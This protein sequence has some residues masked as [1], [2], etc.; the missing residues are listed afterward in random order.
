MAY[1]WQRTEF[2]GL[3]QAMNKTVE[4]PCVRNC[5]LDKQ[6]ICIGCGRTV[7]EI[8]QWQGAD[9]NE[10]QAILKRACTRKGSQTADRLV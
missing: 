5:C 1:L 8:M 3:I 4:S 9:E 10:K 6:D 2:W 7:N